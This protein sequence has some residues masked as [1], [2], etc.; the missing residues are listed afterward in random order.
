MSTSHGNPVLRILHGDRSGGP[1]CASPLVTVT[2]DQMRATGCHYPEAHADPRR[3]ARL[4]RQAHTALGFQGIRVPFDLSVEAEAFGCR[5]KGG[6]AESPPSVAGRACDGQQLL[7]VP[8]GLYGRGRINAVLEAVRIL[9]REFGGRVTLFAGV[10][11]PLTLLGHLFDV[12]RIMRWAIGDPQRLDRNGAV[13]ADFL[14]GYANRLLDAG[15]DAVVISDPTASG[16]LLG[17]RH[18]EKH[19]LPA[20]RRLRERIAGPVVLHICGNTGD[21]LDLL[22]LTGFEGFSFAGPGVPVTAVRRAIGDTMAAIGNIPTHGLLLGGTPAR[23][24][25]ACLQ[26]LDDG[27]DLLAPA[28]GFP[29]HTPS[30]NLE[31]MVRSVEDFRRSGKPALGDPCGEG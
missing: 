27:V 25:E 9:A 7:E 22:P 8:A 3:M 5:I 12:Q 11:G 10:A 17:R 15:A 23:V 13:A 4:A 2:V 26:A 31:A 30:E 19:A 20:Y 6:G 14:A 18:F 1:V 28:C 16:D 21:Y 24:R 29:V